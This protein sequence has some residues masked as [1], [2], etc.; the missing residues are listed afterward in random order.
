MAVCLGV[1][2]RYLCLKS[3]S[4]TDVREVGVDGGDEGEGGEGGWGVAKSC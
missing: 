3:K 1:W 4:G 2:V